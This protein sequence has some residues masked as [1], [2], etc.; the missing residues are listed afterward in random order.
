MLYF[1]A[2]QYDG[3]LDLPL[4]GDLAE[5]LVYDRV[6]SDTERRRIEAY[7][8]ARY[9]VP[10]D[11]S[12]SRV[13]SSEFGGV[14]HLNAADRLVLADASAA[15]NGA[16]LL[17]QPAP[18]T[19]AALAG[20]GVAWGL[21]SQLGRARA[22]PAATAQT[23]S[24]WVKQAASPGAQAVVLAGTNGQPYAALNNTGG[25][26]QVAGTDAASL[27]AP[28]TGTWIHY[29]VAVNA[30]GS[31]QVYGNG[32]P[33]TTVGTALAASLPTGQPLTFGHAASAADDAKTFSGTLDE[34]RLETVSRSA[35]WVRA[36]Y[37]TQA[38]NAAFTGYNHWGTLMLVR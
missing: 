13:W 37:L 5:V 17:G 7:L 6:L 30:S 11:T 8:A 9:A 21:A 38:D 22:Q 23:F 14:W 24:F 1:G 3:T 2:G 20:Q 36:A 15:Q 12:N 26:V 33:L 27:V 31:V 25:N 18:A 16:A 4:D 35:D 28:T 34:L 29:A 19:E 10:T 32:L